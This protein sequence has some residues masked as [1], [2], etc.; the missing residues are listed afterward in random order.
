ME[1]IKKKL[2]CEEAAEILGISVRSFY[3]K[4]QCYESEEFNG[5]FDLRLGRQSSNRA[6][7]REVTFIAKLRTSNNPLI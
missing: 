7:D 2:S 4:R 3:R 5:H 1:A 6:V